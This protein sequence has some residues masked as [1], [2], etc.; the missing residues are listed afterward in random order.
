MYL[1]YIASR[2]LVAGIQCIYII[3]DSGVLMLNITGCKMVTAF[4]RPR[5]V[6]GVMY[7][8]LVHKCSLYI[9]QS[10]YFFGSISVK[11]VLVSA[12]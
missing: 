2:A 11:I 1:I 9:L 8:K 10:G 6:S 7:H 4:D 3:V 12:Y 5:G